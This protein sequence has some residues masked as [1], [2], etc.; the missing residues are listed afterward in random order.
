MKVGLTRRGVLGTGGA[1]LATSTTPTL[2]L[3]MP[4]EGPNTPKL[5]SYISLPPPEAAMRTIKQIG[6]D[7]IDIPTMPPF[8]WTDETFRS[9]M[10]PLKKQ[11]L[12]LGIVMMPW[13]QGNPSARGKAADGGMEPNFLK[14]VH[15]TPGRDEVI[16]KIKQSI[17]AAGKAGLP[18]VEYDFF[19]HRAVEGY[20]D[21]PGRG[22]APMI[23]FD[24]NQMKG[25]PPVPGEG[26]VTREKVWANL[27]YFLKAIVPVAEAANVRLSVHP[28]DPPAP[29][30]RGSGQILNSVADW[31][32]LIEEIPSKYNGITFDCGVT[33]ELGEDPGAV[34][35]YF[36]SRD[37]I[38]QVHFRNVVVDKPVESYTEVFPDNGD[39][40]MRD[41]MRQL[42]RHDYKRL[43]L[44]EHPN[45]IEADRNRPKDGGPSAGW[46]YNTAYARGL[47]QLALLEKM[48][49]KT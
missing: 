14:I 15:G 40:N 36:A 48:E 6:V 4:Q 30:S 2:G 28:N 22:G 5:A 47:L 42:V 45:R 41:V 8:P 27:I 23:H 19:P 35:S 17:H 16:E 33:R 13:W 49:R 20:R 11:G 21:V 9:I 31:K 44:P 25:M 7:Y 24:Y 26:A 18:V 10:D 29:I 43:I 32:R 34:C 12:T 39:N 38:N 37:R 1:M 3:G 46:I